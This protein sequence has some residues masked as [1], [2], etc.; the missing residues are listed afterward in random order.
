MANRTGNKKRSRLDKTFY[1]EAVIEPASIDTKNRIVPVS[2]SSDQPVQRYWWDGEDYNE[3]LGHAK[4]N[5][6]LTRLRD[7]GV[8]LF[9]HDP[10]RPIGKVLNPVIDSKTMKGT[11]A[12]RFDTDEASDVIYQKVL[13]GTLQGV[14]VGY[15]VTDW[16]TVKAGE[17]SADGLYEGPCEIARSWEP[18]EISIVSVPADATVGVGRSMDDLQQLIQK[19][20]AAALEKRQK[21]LEPDRPDEDDE[22]EDDIEELDEDLA[23]DED[24]NEDEVRSDEE[25]D[26]DGDDD[27]DDEDLD[28]EDDEEAPEDTDDLYPECDYLADGECSQGKCPVDG[29]VNCC[30]NCEEQGTCENACQPKMEV[31]RS[32]KNNNAGRSTA[33]LQAARKQAAQA[34]RARV[35]EIRAM[36]RSFREQTGLKED[37]F[38]DNGTSVE[39]TRKALMADI[40][41]RKAAPVV[42]APEIR[43]IADD[44]DKFRAAA[45]DA[46]AWRSG[47]KIA[48]PARGF[49]ALRSVNMVDLG[50]IVYERNTGKR[51][52]SFDR[53][54]LVREMVQSSAFSYIL[55]NVADKAMQNAYQM[56]AVTYPAWTKHGVLNDYKPALRAQLSEVP[57]LDNVSKGSEYKLITLTDAGEWI[58]LSK[59]GNLFSI[60]RE[61]ILNDDMHALVDFPARWASA[62]RMTINQDVYQTLTANPKMGF[63]NTPLFDPAHNN[64]ATNLKKAPSKD[65]LQAAIQAMMLQT[66]LKTATPLN[67]RPKFLL[68][69]VA[70]MFGAK[71]LVQSAADPTAPN[72]GAVNVLQ[73]IVTL[74]TD[75]L[76]DV[77]N[78][79]A[80]YLAADP[81]VTD[82]IEVA[83]LNGQDTP[84]IEQQNG[85][86][87]DG[88]TF[89]IRIEYGVK[90]LDWRGLYLNPGK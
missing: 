8:A 34:E 86:N 48:K 72:A 44:E 64:I 47:L 87:V 57:L 68:T 4:G 74:V 61:D 55:Q 40:A 51:F 71:Q 16:E 49:E 39:K 70:L 63:D 42:Q 60:T 26:R 21:A 41:K 7:I 83:F 37:A 59:R 85:F 3:I 10:A 90:A 23:E 66:G 30:L 25:E 69:P 56:A 33:A 6:D 50:R 11:A 81:A 76:L 14:S 29:S 80:W 38:I 31:M 1:R 18:F 45:V 82:T 84:Y 9:N 65:S 52:D 32:M 88:V 36:F 20:V 46:L 54:L 62:A 17:F 89:K 78:N 75:P 73:D 53:D 77:A 67:I 22:D 5:A 24:L 19:A 58:Q 15:R 28:E 79:S 27:Q 2:F 43:I 13:S 35:M 12:I